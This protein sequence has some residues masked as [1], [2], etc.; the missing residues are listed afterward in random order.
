M[1]AVA[2]ALVIAG[3]GGP[4]PAAPRPELPP[5]ATTSLGAI[6][7]GPGARWAIVGSPKAV[8]GG[9]F[10]PRVDKIVPKQGL[11]K[12]QARL[13]FDLRA[14]PRAL[15]IGYAATTFYAARLPDGTAP[16]SALDAFD[17]RVLPPKGKA[18]PRP[19]LVRLWGSM[20]SGVRGS[21]AG[22]W[23]SLGDA[24]VGEGGRL[25]PVLASMALATGKRAPERAITADKT[26]G[27]LL[28]WAEPAEIGVVVRCPLAESLGG[29]PEGKNVLLQECFGVGLTL[30]PAPGGKLG[31]AARVTGA[32]GKD[33]PAAAEAMRATFASVAESDLGRVLGL[34]DAQPTVKATA[35]AVDGELV[36]DADVFATG[37]RRVLAAEIDDATN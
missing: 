19:D 9:P 12:L 24:I 23:S 5:L 16:S 33:A 26:F 4:K 32:W 31:I 11:D 1:R 37:L 35:D 27:P 34:R 3:C 2:I 13:G 30:R 14:T 36:V 29:V 15:M 7:Q 21:A 28:S 8:F 6:A 18:T 20:P 22:M 25:G 10:G 17:K